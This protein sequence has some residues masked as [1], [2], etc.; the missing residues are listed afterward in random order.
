MKEEG[1][2]LKSEG[3]MTVVSVSQMQFGKDLWGHEPRMVETSKRWR[4]QEN[5]FYLRA[6][7]KKWSPANT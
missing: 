2:E 3:E 7:R 5:E 4:K 6:S 1:R